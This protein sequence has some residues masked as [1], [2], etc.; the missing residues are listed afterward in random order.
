MAHDPRGP[1]R[2]ASSRQ[3]FAVDAGVGAPLPVEDD[4]DVEDDLEDDVAGAEDDDEESGDDDD[5][6]AAAELA[7]L[8]PLLAAGV[9]A[10]LA[11][12]ESVR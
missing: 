6:D 11:D 9:V 10:E 2:P 3:D 8:L 7:D 12:R 4:D 5:E 1:R